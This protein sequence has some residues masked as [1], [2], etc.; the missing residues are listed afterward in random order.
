MKMILIL[1]FPI[2]V[3]RVGCCFF[4]AHVLKISLSAFKLVIKHIWIDMFCAAC[5]KNVMIN[6]APGLDITKFAILSAEAL[7]CVRHP[8]ERAQAAPQQYCKGHTN[9]V[10]SMVISNWLTVLAS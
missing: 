6:V 8:V 2:L 7:T 4:I 3:I 5:H 10:V 9:S 1:R